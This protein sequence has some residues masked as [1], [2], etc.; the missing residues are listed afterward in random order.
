MLQV[1]VGFITACHQRYDA[2]GVRGLKL[3]YWGTQGYLGVEQKQELFDWLAQKDYWTIEEI[4]AHIEETY[5]VIYQSQQS[6]YTLLKQAGFSW[7]KSQPTH[8]DKDENRVLEKKKEIM[9]LLVKWRG[10]IASGQ[11]RVLFVD[12]C[13]LLWGDISGYGWSRRNERVD[14]E[15]K[16]TRERQ[17]Y[18][19]ALDYLTKQ[20]F[21]N[22]YS[23]GNEDNTVAFLKY[24]QSLFAKSTRLMIIW[25]GATYH[26]SSVIQEFLSQVND[27]L[28]P[29]KWKIT[30]IRLAP[31]A[32][33]QNP[34]EDVW[35][36]AK[37][38]IRKF[39]RL[40]QKFRSVKLLFKLFT[41]LQTFTFAKAFMYGYCS[42]PI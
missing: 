26:R 18:Y 27:T 37:Q 1:S 20:F 2:A 5:E 7:K 23:A 42:S 33:Q 25:D 39:S 9:E 15:V 8:P 35:L 10:E 29:E 16:S 3:N 14:V 12:E 19:G 21:V 38:F 11:V 34:V 30:C 22:E 31:N 28:L 4:V 32:P 40:C 13:H 24:L 6:Y 41:H 17:T 36:Q